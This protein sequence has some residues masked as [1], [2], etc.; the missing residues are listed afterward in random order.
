MN[1]QHDHCNNQ[2]SCCHYDKYIVR[3]L[4]VLLLLLL[5]LLQLV[6]IIY[7]FNLKEYSA[8]LPVLILVRDL[9]ILFIHKLPCLSLQTCDL[10]I[11]SIKLLTSGSSDVFKLLIN[12]TQLIHLG[13]QLFYLNQILLIVIFLLFILKIRHCVCSVYSAAARLLHI[14]KIL[15][16]SVTQSFVISAHLLRRI[17]THC[18]HKC[19]LVH[20]KQDTSVGILRH[21]S[22]I[23]PALYIS[24]RCT[25]RGHVEIS[26]HKMTLSSICHL[27]LSGISISTG[28]LS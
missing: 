28:W 15:L 20:I 11:I 22:L 5:F 10:H 6:L 16:E 9:S 19:A 14:L 21:K 17:N 3:Q 25:V 18:I 13:F 7:S 8:S 24:E 4:L 1:H 23:L 12:F 26:L 27:C 2:Y